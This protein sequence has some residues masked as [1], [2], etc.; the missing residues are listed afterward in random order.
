MSYAKEIRPGLF[1]GGRGPGGECYHKD[2][3]GL[4]TFSIWVR[5]K[6]QQQ[7]TPEDF[8]AIAADMRARANEPGDKS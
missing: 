5:E 3:D 7:W 6:D 4:T 1:Y 2:D 8:E